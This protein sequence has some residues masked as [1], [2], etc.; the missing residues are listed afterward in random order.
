MK[1]SYYLAD[2][3]Q[4][5]LLLGTK[6]TVEVITRRKKSHSRGALYKKLLVHRVDEFLIEVSLRDYDGS[7]FVFLI[8]PNA[9]LGRLISPCFDG[10]SYEGLFLGQ[11]WSS[12]SDMLRQFRK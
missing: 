4:V 7:L 8:N 10:S 12:V 11:L 6:S 5:A 1:K 9:E 3:K 2:A